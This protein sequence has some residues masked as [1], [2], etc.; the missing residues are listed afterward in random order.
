ME[1]LGEASHHVSRCPTSPSARGWRPERMSGLLSRSAGGA[2]PDTYGIRN[3]ALRSFGPKSLCT[4]EQ[5]RGCR[6]LRR[7]RRYTTTGCRPGR[8]TRTSQERDYWGCHGREP[9]C[10]VPQT[11]DLQHPQGHVA[12]PP[13]M[14][15][16][17]GHSSRDAR[18]ATVRV[19][20]PPQSTRP[21]TGK[22]T[23]H[24]YRQSSCSHTHRRRLRESGLWPCRCFREERTGKPTCLAGAGPQSRCLQPRCS[25]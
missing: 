12:S 4:E 21:A 20:M 2:G 15:L 16:R 7:D 10:N 9:T 17:R 22:E 5:E 6:N 11:R 24:G 1:I 8:A 13:Q 19:L 23:G 14:A 3:R 25:P 18:C